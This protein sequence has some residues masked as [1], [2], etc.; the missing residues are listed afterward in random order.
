MLRLFEGGRIIARKAGPR[1]NRF[2]PVSFFL[3]N[4]SARAIDQRKTTQ[5]WVAPTQVCRKSVRAGWAEASKKLA[6]R[7]EHRLVWPELSNRGDAKL[8]W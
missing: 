7:G 2:R 3:T 6:K 8:K 1:W 4:C 5:G